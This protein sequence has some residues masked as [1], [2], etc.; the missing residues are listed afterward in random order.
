[1]ILWKVSKIYI[2][3]NKHNI[4]SSGLLLVHLWK[5]HHSAT[6]CMCNVVPRY[7]YPRASSPVQSFWFWLS[8][9][10][11]FCMTFWRLLEPLLPSTGAFSPTYESCIGTQCTKMWL[12]FAMLVC[13]LTLWKQ[14][15]KL[16]RRQVFTVVM[17][18]FPYV[19]ACI[20]LCRQSWVLMSTTR[21]KWSATCASLVSSVACVSK[22]WILVSRTSRTAGAGWGGAKQE[23]S[24]IS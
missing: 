4:L 24:K 10:L 13:M 6:L 12:L 19:C 14:S 18:N 23:K 5:I 9:S 8:L 21:M 17:L 22:Q 15:Q 3:S 1:M 2:K 20:F 7:I 11:W 16:V